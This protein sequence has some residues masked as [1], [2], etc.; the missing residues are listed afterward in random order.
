M[1]N[2]ISSSGVYFPTNSK[3]CLFF[4]AG[5]Q[6]VY[7]LHFLNPISVAEHLGWFHNLAI[8]DRCADV[9]G[10]RRCLWDV[11]AWRPLGKDLGVGGMAGPYLGSV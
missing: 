7:R 3:S 8:V 6:L 9:S 1:L 5:R 2:T 10:I 11:L 4:L